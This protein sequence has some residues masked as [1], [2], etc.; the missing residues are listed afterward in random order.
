MHEMVFFYKWPLRNK[1]TTRNNG[2]G[3]HLCLLKWSC[4]LGG[5]EK[6]ININKILLF[7]QK[8]T[9]GGHMISILLTHGK[10]YDYQGT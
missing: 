8:V 2:T 6:C 4:M 9:R 3:A 1:S 5:I 7:A 10:Y